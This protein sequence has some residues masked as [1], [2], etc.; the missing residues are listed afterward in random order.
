MRMMEK[1]WNRHD[2]QWTLQGTGCLF[3]GTN[4]GSGL[5][6]IGGDEGSG[7]KVEEGT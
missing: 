4:E 6:K 3:N 7:V 1:R 2:G 5:E